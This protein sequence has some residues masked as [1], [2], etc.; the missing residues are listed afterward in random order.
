MRKQ[1]FIALVIVLAASTTMFLLMAFILSTVPNFSRSTR[2]MAADVI[3][4]TITALEPSS[5][6]NDLETAI[7]ITGTDFTAEMSGTLVFTSPTAYLG[8]TALM[9]VTW[10][11]STSMTATVPWGLDPG[12]Y[13][14]T[15][16]NPDGGTGS[17]G[18]AFT[19]T[20]GIGQWNGGNLFGGT[21]IQ[22]LMKPGDPNTLYARVDEVGEFRSH[23]AGE[24]WQFIDNEQ[25]N[26]FVSDPN[27]PSRLYSYR[28]YGLLRSEDEGDTWTL[29]LNQWPDGQRLGEGQVYVSP[30]DAQTLFYSSAIAWDG[31]YALGL[32]KSTDGGV[33]W[34]I[35][36]DMEG[37]P[38]RTLAFNS[39]D[40]QE[41]VLGTSDGRVFQSTDGGDQ[42]NEVAKP[43]I[44]DIGV[45]TYNP[46]VS[47][48]VWAAGAWFTGS[49]GIFKSVNNLSTWE[50][51]APP[52][53]ATADSI[54]FASATSVYLAIHYAGGWYSNNDGESWEPFGPPT[55]GYDIAFNQSDTSLF[56]MGGYQYGVHK[57]TD[58]GQTWE[59]KNQGLSA[60]VAIWI[61]A[62]QND[63][64]RVYAIID[65]WQ[66][67]FCSNDSAASWEFIPVETAWNISQV[68]VDPFN[69]QRIYLA[70]DSGFY[71]SEDGGTSWVLGDGSHP[72]Q[73]LQS[74]PFNQGR[75]LAIGISLLVPGNSALYVSTDSGQKWDEVIIPP[76]LNY[77]R[78]IAF[79]PLYPGMVYLTTAGS[80]LYRSQ[81]YGITW[82]PIATEYPELQQTFAIAIAASPQPMIVVAGLLHS[83]YRSLDGGETWAEVGCSAG[84][85]DIGGILARF[86]FV[87]EDSRRFYAA[88]FEKLFVS[89]DGVDTCHPASGALGRMRTSALS[90]TGSG[91]QIIL[92]A[93]TTGG[94][95]GGTLG[96]VIG[97]SQG[98]I[99]IESDL[100]E[101]GI[102]RFAQ[103]TWQT[104]L[105]MALR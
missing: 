97:A 61:D 41:M 99:V 13:T 8:S 83:S 30:Q 68:L 102:Y 12:G 45:I 32:I 22:I 1:S 74:D 89:V 79:D 15:V 2:A 43:P 11:N 84:G 38:V 91:D 36:A 16:V 33:S 58:G 37:T 44:D 93:A 72:F 40:P 31:I 29:I 77:I 17:L 64:R 62:P 42:W 80:G 104:F 78:E 81:D 19:V 18:N 60:L 49:P 10:V 100:M 98:S 21:V 26:D 5:A 7:V 76:D 24:T 94:D 57:T 55:G 103:H 90:Y 70:A 25:S 71:I 53:V 73:F 96:R 28:A 82:E 50:N 65:G 95:M 47:G 59:V 9:D 92:Y 87:D 101:A 27:N 23:D 48:E 56:Y 4:P 52:N 6:F 14:L 35:V 63:R 3:T 51:V 105:P 66:G 54:D 88:T 69:S 39:E 46:Y 75:L 85:D 86:L 20:Q 67:V 34:G